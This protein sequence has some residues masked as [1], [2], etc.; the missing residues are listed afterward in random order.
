MLSSSHNHFVLCLFLVSF[1]SVN[2]QSFPNGYVVILNNETP[3]VVIGRCY[4]NGELSHESEISLNSGWSDNFARD[5]AFGKN[6]T[7]SCDLKLGEK[8]G[9]FKLFDLN[10][11]S[12]CHI[13]SEE[14]RW[15]I[16]EDGLCMFSAGVCKMFK[17]ETTLSTRHIAGES[18]RYNIA[19]G[20][21]K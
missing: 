14:C 19:N 20:P 11:T 3:I 12:I 21:T 5:I 8:H 18:I 6:N 9:F 17:W 7:F 10:D 2:S 16:Q 4:M 13:P 1:L 15:K